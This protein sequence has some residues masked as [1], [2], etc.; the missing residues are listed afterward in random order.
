MNIGLVLAPILK[1]VK[2]LRMMTKMENLKLSLTKQ[3]KL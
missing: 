2:K 1:T 3:N